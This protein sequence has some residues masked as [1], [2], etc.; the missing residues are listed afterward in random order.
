MEKIL[1]V[2]NLAKSFDDKE[3]HRDVSFSLYQGETLGLL[4]HSGT[5]KSVL[6]R[7]LIGLEQIDSGQIIYRDRRIDDL[8]E[9]ELYPV[10]TKIS[11]SFQSGALFDSIS[12][13]EN[14]A[15]PLFEHTK[16]G[17]KEV[18][19]K[20]RELLKIVNLEATEDLM[21]SDLSGGMQKRVGLARSLALD[22][23]IL[24]YDEPTAGLDPQ[25]IEKIIDLIN[26]CRAKGF[27]GILVTHDIPVARRVCDRL[28]IIND[29]Q[30]H[31]TGTVQEFNTSED[32]FVKT[33]LLNERAL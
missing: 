33:F 4:G 17:E 6:L 24:L 21:P 10:R 32:D 12:V 29:G 23:D 1:E 19:E 20:V 30:V 26:R 27:S 25:N 15:Y 18:A 31:F 2:K 3:V 5:G 7:S 16:L 8:S 22:P 11:Y 13:F 28:V 14:I 9:K